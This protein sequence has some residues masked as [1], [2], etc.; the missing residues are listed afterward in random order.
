MKTKYTRADKAPTWTF[1]VLKALRAADDFQSVAQIR[2]ATGG[3]S[4]QITAAL[5]HLKNKA[6]AVDSVE[7]GGSLW[8]FVTGEDKRPVTRD[9]RAV[10]PKGNRARRVKTS[11]GA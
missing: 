11:K 5:W 2:E 6:S 7:S 3:S 10:E 1:R 4:N 9:E 8:W